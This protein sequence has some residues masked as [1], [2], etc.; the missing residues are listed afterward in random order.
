[1]AVT[2]PKSSSLAM[3]F[4]P[5]GS[6]RSRGL[7]LGNKATSGPR[8]QER[9]RRHRAEVFFS[10]VPRPVVGT[11]NTSTTCDEFR[12]LKD[13]GSHEQQWSEVMNRMYSLLSEL[14]EDHSRFSKRG[15][16]CYYLA[17][18]RRALDARRF[19]NG[20][21]SDEGAYKR[22]VDVVNKLSIQTQYTKPH[23]Q[24]TT[25]LRS[26]PVQACM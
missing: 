9:T 12:I 21:R 8:L 22:T 7:I 11:M 2:A 14:R 19:I 3:Y 13:D 20:R 15:L 23:Y 16:R 6:S 10:R 26:R 18:E 17:A 1:M 25:S 24:F 5:L 4:R